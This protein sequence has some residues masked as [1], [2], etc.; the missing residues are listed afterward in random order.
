M[1]TRKKADIQKAVELYCSTDRLNNKDI[2]ALFS[3]ST[4]TA[5]QLKKLAIEKE[6][7]LNTMPPS[8]TT[9]NLLVAFK[10]WG[11]DIKDCERRLL[12]KRFL[13]TK[14]AI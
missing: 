5:L 11:I 2:M 14:G 4:S 9:V 7:E 10:A 13:Q 12:K 1:N 8:P 6:C 3:C